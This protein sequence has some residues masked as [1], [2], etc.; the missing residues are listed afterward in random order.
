MIDLRSMQLNGGL[1]L[2]VR[3]HGRSRPRDDIGRCV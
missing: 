2:R 3:G 1:N